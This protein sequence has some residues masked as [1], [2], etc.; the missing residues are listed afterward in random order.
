MSCVMAVANNARRRPHRSTPSCCWRPVTRCDST[1]RHQQARRAVTCSQRQRNYSFILCDVCKLSQP[2]VQSAPSAARVEGLARD[3]TLARH[4]GRQARD[5]S[6][7]YRRARS[8]GAKS[9]WVRARNAHA[10]RAAVARGARAEVQA[11][12]RHPNEELRWRI[13][14]VRRLRQRGA[15]PRRLPSRVG[16]TRVRAVAASVARLACLA[17][18]RFIH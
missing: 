5:R 14:C 16:A 7:A 6:R 2:P 18:R 13:A 9:C 8:R 11:A 1:V 4:R 15:V 12:P 10:R 17:R 3:P